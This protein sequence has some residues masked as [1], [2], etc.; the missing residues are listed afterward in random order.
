MFDDSS[1]EQR[2]FGGSNDWQLIAINQ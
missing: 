2:L 1:G